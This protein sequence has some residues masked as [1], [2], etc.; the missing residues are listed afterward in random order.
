MDIKQNI[1]DAVNEWLTPSFD[2]ET[3][4]AVKALMGSLPELEESFYKN[5]EF[6]TG[7][8]RGVMGVGTIA[9]N[10]YTLEK[11]PR[12][13]ML[14]LVSRTNLKAVIAYDCRQN[15]DTLAKTVADVFSANGIEVYLFSIKT[16]TRVVFFE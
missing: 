4:E 12:K 13:S 11:V 9:Y 10:K 1:L 3:Q 15:S 7:G 6:G 2:K 5:L 14:K 8:M 16:Y